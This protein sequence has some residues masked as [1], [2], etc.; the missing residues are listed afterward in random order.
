[1]NPYLRYFSCSV[2][3]IFLLGAALNFTLDPLG[4]FRNHGLHP[5]TFLEQ[6]V[7]GDERAAFD[8]SI[9]SYRPDTVIAGNSRVRHGFAADDAHLRERLGVI[10]NLGLP[11]ADIGELDRYIRKVL[12]NTPT[13]KLMIGLDFGQF[14]RDRDFGGRTGQSDSR[15]AGRL[16]PDPVMNL[17]SALWSENAFRA[18]A[19]SLLMPHNTTL[20]G[21]SNAQHALRRVRSSGHRLMTR[22]AETR[23]AQRYSVIDQAIFAARMATLDALLAEICRK[24]TTARL[25]ISPVH[26]R[27]LLLIRELGQLSMFHGWK[28][29]LA[30]MVSQHQERGCAVTL[31]DFTIISEYITEPFP[32]SGDRQHRM[33]WYWESSHYNHKM[34]HMIVDRLW[35]ENEG[36]RDFGKDITTENV[37]SLLEQERQKLQALAHEQPL[38]VREIRGLVR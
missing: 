13:A 24:G 9:E 27:Q 23:I 6:R 31:T 10:L 1:M 17:V 26:I 11:G 22:R 4:Y 32:E 8:L 36:D 38:L 2:L 12:D 21:G 3:A 28:T 7:W 18:S 37:R 20:N 30:A 25:F 16:L 33:Q 19:E 14:L 35:T 34:G 5:G 15:Q 29:Q